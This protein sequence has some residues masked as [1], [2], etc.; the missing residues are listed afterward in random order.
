MRYKSLCIILLTTLFLIIPSHLS[1]AHKPQPPLSPSTYQE[2]TLLIFGQ[3]AIGTLTPASPE[4]SWIFNAPPSTRASLSLQRSSGDAKLTMML[5]N[6]SGAIIISLSTDLQGFVSVPQ[7][8]LEGGNYNLRLV[9][10]F[11]N[12]NADATYE[13]ILASPETPAPIISP[14]FPTLSSATLAPAETPL[15]PTATAT[16][17]TPL[18]STIIQIG[19]VLEGEFLSGGQVD[20]YSF[21]AVAGAYITFGLS[22]LDDAD[23]DPYIELIS[24]SGTVIAQNDNHADSLD[25]LVIHFLLPE[26]GNYTLRASSANGQGSG[27][28]LLALGEGFILRDMERGVAIHNQPHIAQ[29]EA[30][31]V[32]DVWEIEAVAGD[33]ISISI[34]KWGVDKESLFDPMVELL[35]PTGETLAFDDDSGANKN[36]IIT[37]IEAPISGIYRIHVAAYSHAT[38]GLYR[39]WW[40]RD[41][42]FPTATPAPTSALSATPAINATPPPESSTEITPSPTLANAPLLETPAVL[43]SGVSGSEQITVEFGEIAVRQ[44]YLTINQK[45]SIFVEGHWSFD[46]ILELYTPDG[47]MLDRV[48]DT[49]AAETF[50][51]NPRLLYVAQEDGSYFIYIY[52]YELSAGTFTLH[53]RIE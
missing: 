33:R 4:R 5:F 16:L 1:H 42:A 28:Y 36:A 6:Q 32:R 29:L 40:Q 44:L 7:L 51:I 21:P 9:A 49:G 52:G 47:Y 25:A 27:D 48:D 39:L 43:L 20:H 37:S 35:S 3:P 12:S 19:D 31:G 15:M 26:T 2:S 22:R 50:D 41:N 38:I 11:S 45:L 17:F 46:G 24:P 8:F 23:F 53:W 30:Y 34:E 14:P 10:D 18:A 13:I